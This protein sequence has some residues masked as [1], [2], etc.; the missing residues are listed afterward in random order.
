MERLRAKGHTLGQIARRLG[1]SRQRV[2]N[3]LYRQPPLPG[4]VACCHCQ[5]RLS[6]TVRTDDRRKLLCRRCL[7]KVLDFSFAQRLA[8]LR[9]LAG[10]S[11]AALA[12][13]T[14]IG[15]ATICLL[16]LGRYKP[17]KRTRIGLLAFLESVSAKRR[18]H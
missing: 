3:A 7:T 15:Q 5:A 12:Q 4:P 1:V 10:L 6:T 17:Q 9:F 13:A 14:G 16:E 8:S 2:H 18:K 11:Q